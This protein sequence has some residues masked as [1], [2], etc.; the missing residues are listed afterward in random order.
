MFVVLCALTMAMVWAPVS[1]HYRGNTYL[2]VLHEVPMLLGLVFLSPTLL[3]LCILTAYAFVFVVIRRQALMKAM[4]N[5]TSNGL[6]AAF[7]A[8]VYREILGAQSPVSFRGWAAAAAALCTTAVFSTIAVWFVMRLHGRT[9]T[10]RRTPIQFTMEATLIAASMCLSF[11][12]LDAAWFDPLDDVAPAPGRRA[13]HRGLPGVQPPFPPL[14]SAGAP[15]RL[16]SERWARRAS[17]PRP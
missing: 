15:L 12:V 3:V 14:L 2:F 11:V 17:N 13:D 6:S 10:A 8:V 1:L 9:A 7:A 4:F 5:I 16:Q